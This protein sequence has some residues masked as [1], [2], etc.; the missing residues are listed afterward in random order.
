MTHRT[1]AERGFTLIELLVVV[2]IIAMLIAILLPAL[3]EAKE[4]ARRLKCCSNIRQLNTACITHAEEHRSSLYIATN[5]TGSDSLAH[6]YPTYLPDPQIGVCPSTANIVREDVWIRANPNRWRRPVLRDLDEAADHGQDSGGGHSYEVW[7]WFDGTW[8]GGTP[9]PVM[10]PDGTIVD[11][12]KV[13]TVLQQLGLEPG[14]DWYG[15]WRYNDYATPDVVKKHRSVPKPYQTLLV[16]DNDQ[17]GGGDPVEGENVNNW[18]DG[19]DNH[20]PLGLNI[21]FLDGH[22]RWYDRNEKLLDA[23][24]Y[25]CAVPPSNWDEAHPHLGGRWEGD[26]WVWYYR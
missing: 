14:D 16:L 4:R 3:S 19:A 22:A 24:L 13:G 11:G 5:D 2:A 21:G 17:G 25:S 8:R 1:P 23:Y 20:A 6:I 26:M 12:S 18:P 9:A 10:Y 7:G 15:Y